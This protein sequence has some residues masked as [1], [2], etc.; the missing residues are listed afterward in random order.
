MPT[1]NTRSSVMAEMTGA[2]PLMGL[3]D[4]PLFAAPNFAPPAPKPLATRAP[5]VVSAALF[6][7]EARETDYSRWTKEDLADACKKLGLSRT[8]N[9]QDLINYLMNPESAPK[10][11]VSSQRKRKRGTD[12]DD[13]AA[14]KL[15]VPTQKKLSTDSPMHTSLEEAADSG[16]APLADKAPQDGGKPSKA[17]RKRLTMPDV[18]RRHGLQLNLNHYNPCFRQWAS[19]HSPKQLDAMLSTP[20]NAMLDENRNDFVL[21]VCN[22][23][24]DTYEDIT[25]GEW[26]GKRFRQRAADHR[27]S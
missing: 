17:E 26:F 11:R 27:H 23:I 9:R 1:E 20:C 7:Q 16:D 14:L 13:G 15:S 24:G 10:G 2:G 18:L 21:E 8:G 22:I 12:A 5:E 6:P 3:A 19:K 4:A 25:M